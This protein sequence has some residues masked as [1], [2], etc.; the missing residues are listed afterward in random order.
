MV[1]EQNPTNPKATSI[2]LLLCYG[3]I[4]RMKGWNT[5][6]KESEVNA[7]KIT[8]LWSMNYI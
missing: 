3:N 2:L 6:P 7:L 1:S 8:K 4:I 5:V